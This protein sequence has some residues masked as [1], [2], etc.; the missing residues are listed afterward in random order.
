MPQV[1]QI[2][3]DEVLEIFNKKDDNFSFID[4][5]EPEEWEQGTI[6]NITKISLGEFS[7]NISNLDKSKKYILVCR[8]G[9]RSNRAGEIMLNQGFSDVSN[10]SGGMLSWYDNDYPLD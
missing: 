3:V 2:E 10:F 4:V 6:P 9:A 7:E 1:N 8:S 5:R